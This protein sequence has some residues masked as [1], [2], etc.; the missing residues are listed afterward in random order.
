MSDYSILE[1]LNAKNAVSFFSKILV[2]AVLVLTVLSPYLMWSA[3]STQCG[4]DDDASTTSC[5]TTKIVKIAT[6]VFGFTVLAMYLGAQ[7][8]K[9]SD[10]ASGYSLAMM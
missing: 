9:N 8:Q 10:A 6:S 3:V 2:L 5:K 1:S 4:Q 7:I